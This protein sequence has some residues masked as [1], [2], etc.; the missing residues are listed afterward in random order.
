MAPT[1]HANTGD[2]NAILEYLARRRGR[3]RSVRR[4]TAW[5]SWPDWT[6]NLS[7]AFWSAN[8]RIRFGFQVPG[9]CF[10]R[11]QMR[12]EGI[13]ERR[14]RRAR[15]IAE[16]QRKAEVERRFQEWQHRKE[17]LTRLATGPLEAAARIAAEMKSR[18]AEVLV[19]GGF[20]RL[21]QLFRRNHG[22]STD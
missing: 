21:I 14:Q 12:V 13:L 20:G 22:L 18:I 16:A 7:Q 15:Q 1:A 5:P 17:T 9:R 6:A 3:R 4:N 11:R 8:R 10:R 2:T 19:E